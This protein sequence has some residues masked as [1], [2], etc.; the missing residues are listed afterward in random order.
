AADDAG[1]DAGSWRPAELAGGADGELSAFGG[2]VGHGGYPVGDLAEAAERRPCGRRPD[3]GGAGAA[4]VAEGYG[5]AGRGRGGRVG[6]VKRAVEG[7]A[8]TSSNSA[9]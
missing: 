6:G 5:A 9:G 8:S 7:H 4:D 3:V 1:A 2:V